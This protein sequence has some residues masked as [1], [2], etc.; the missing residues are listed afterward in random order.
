MHAS[1]ILKLTTRKVQDASS[2]SHA[3]ISTVAIDN[4]VPAYSSKESNFCGI[5]SKLRGNAIHN[6]GALH[7]QMLTDKRIDKYTG[8]PNDAYNTR[9]RRCSQDESDVTVTKSNFA[10]RSERFYHNKQPLSDCEWSLHEDR[11]SWSLSTGDTLLAKCSNAFPATPHVSKAQE[12]LD[13]KQIN[14]EDSDYSDGQESVD[15]CIQHP[16]NENAKTHT[17]SQTKNDDPPVLGNDISHDLHKTIAFDGNIDASNKHEYVGNASSG[18]RHIDMPPL[19]S[20]RIPASSNDVIANSDSNSKLLAEHVPSHAFTPK[21]EQTLMSSSNNANSTQLSLFLEEQWPG[22]AVV[23]PKP[24]SELLED[25][26]A[27]SKINQTSFNMQMRL[28]YIPITFMALRLPPLIR[29]IIDFF[30]FYNTHDSIAWNVVMAITI[31]SQGW[32][33]FFCFVVFK[34]QIRRKYVQLTWRIWSFIRYIFCFCCTKTLESE[35]TQKSSNPIPH[36]EV[37]CV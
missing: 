11:S 1:A 2:D 9:S 37:V 21:S 30:G 10:N 27:I 19:S 29:N 26:A 13:A 16:T 35:S 18:K 5:A 8:R 15:D 24:E 22:A 33:N 3:V 31:P 25:S 17:E 32:V 4:G 6:R 20:A 36:G 7:H 34:T 23:I 14:E 12:I 28:M